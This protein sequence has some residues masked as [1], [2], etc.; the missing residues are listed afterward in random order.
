AGAKMCDVAFCAGKA[1]ADQ[2]GKNGSNQCGYSEREEVN[3]TGGTPLNFVW[4]DFLN[5]RV[6]N[7]CRAGGNSKNQAAYCRRSV[8]GTEGDP[9]SGQQHGDRSPDEHRFAT[10]YSISEPADQRTTDYPSQWNEGTGDHGI[11]IAEHLVALKEGDSPSH[12]ANGG[13]HKQES[14]Y[15]PAQIRLR[16]SKYDRARSQH[17]CPAGSRALRATFAW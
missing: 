4:V 3:R 13:G 17:C 7:H 8:A 11:V 15:R 2:I 12:I 9:R 5:D 14:C 6:R 16:V 1:L 10:A